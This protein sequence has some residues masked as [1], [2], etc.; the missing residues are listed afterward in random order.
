MEYFYRGMV[1]DGGDHVALAFRAW[2]KSRVRSAR[3]SP[4]DLRVRP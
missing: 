3:T 4:F 2:P 1:A